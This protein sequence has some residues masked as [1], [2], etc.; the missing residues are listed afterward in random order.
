MGILVFGPNEKNLPLERSISDRTVRMFYT[1]EY[2]LASYLYEVPTQFL[3]SPCAEGFLYC[4]YYVGSAYDQ[5]NF[6]SAGFSMIRF[7][8]MF[9]YMM[10]SD[11]VTDKANHTDSY[12]AGGDVA[13]IESYPDHTVTTHSHRLLVGNNCYEFV[14]RISVRND[15][16]FDSADL[17]KTFDRFFGAIELRDRTHV[18][19]PK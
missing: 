14:S 3:S 16:E 17:E 19:F 15:Q 12:T 7:P 6:D 13:R 8:D 1:K 10:P 18:V 4:V 9:E 2:S 11:C 5:S